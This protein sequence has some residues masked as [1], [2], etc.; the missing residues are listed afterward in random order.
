VSDSVR[1]PT[2]N[3]IEIVHDFFVL[4]SQNPVSVPFQ[5]LGSCSIVVEPTRVDFTV[6]LNDESVC[7][8]AEVDDV[9]PQ[10]MLTTELQTAEALSPEG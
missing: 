1:N 2:E 7:W 5:M 10:W 9:R 3:A 4:E 8:T 6:D